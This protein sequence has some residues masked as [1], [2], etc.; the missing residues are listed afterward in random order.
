MAIVNLDCF[1]FSFTILVSPLPAYFAQ[2][3][4]VNAAEIVKATVQ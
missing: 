4:L 2:E 1:K 3:F